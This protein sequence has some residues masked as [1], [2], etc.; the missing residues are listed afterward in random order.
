VR[1]AVG[2]QRQ[3]PTP[4]PARH[5]TSGPNLPRDPRSGED[6]RHPAPARQAAPILGIGRVDRVAE[7]GAPYG[8]G[9][10]GRGRRTHHARV[11]GSERVLC[12]FQDAAGRA[13]MRVSSAD[14]IAGQGPALR[15][16]TRVPGYLDDQPG[17]GG[18]RA[19]RGAPGRADVRLAG[20]GHAPACC[21]RRHAQQRDQQVPRAWPRRARSHCASGV[22]ATVAVQVVAVMCQATS[23]CYPCR[24]HA[25]Q[26]AIAAFAVRMRPWGGPGCRVV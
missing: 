4:T 22:P 6:R 26:L 11:C 19:D 10:R 20:S 25:E 23:T 16:G 24:S 9:R 1:S 12:V 14:W 13:G 17:S 21:G 2:P 18:G 5:R 8:R 15:L 7:P 3:R